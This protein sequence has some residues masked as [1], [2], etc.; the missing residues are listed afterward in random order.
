MDPSGAI[1]GASQ[2]NTTPIVATISPSVKYYRKNRDAILA[3]EREKKR[4][5]DYYERN[6]EAVRLRQKEAYARKKAL[7]AASLPPPLTST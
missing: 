3:R 2:N 5:L 7:T 4:W 1:S 6:K